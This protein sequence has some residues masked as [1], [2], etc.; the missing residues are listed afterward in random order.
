V[1]R[2]CQV[3]HKLSRVFNSVALARLADAARATKG[4]IPRLMLVVAANSADPEANGTI[5]VPETCNQILRHGSPLSVA[6]A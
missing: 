1:P 4:I 3:L 5:L 2:R 6:G